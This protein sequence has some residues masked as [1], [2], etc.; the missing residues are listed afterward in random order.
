M[1]R[2]ILFTSISLCIL[3]TFA[4]TSAHA[5]A[6]WSERSSKSYLGREMRVAFINEGS[7]KIGQIILLSRGSSRVKAKYFASGDVAGK[8]KSFAKNKK[9]LFVSSGAFTGSS[10]KP[11]GLTIDN[12]ET[13]NRHIITPNSP[14]VKKLER[15]VTMDGLVIVEAVGGVRATDIKRKY[16][17][18]YDENVKHQIDLFRKDDLN[19]FFDWAKK[20]RA[21]V[22]Q[23]MLLAHENNLMVKKSNA[24]FNARERRFLVLAKDT[25][26]ILYHIIFYFTKR[27]FLNEIAENTYKYLK[28]RKDMQVI[29][30]L[31]LDTGMYNIQHVYEPYDGR[32][33]TDY[34]GHEEVDIDN[35][36]NL[37]A[38]YY[39]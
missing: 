12:G 22:F 34:R 25:N 16:L 1:T 27:Y 5:Y 38:Y 26:G 6:S 33:L 29:A 15:K 35:A 8:Y 11:R 14:K 37:L 20:Y 36:T 7:R 17:N 9:V 23:T 21:T 2:S 39:E 32:E 18:I 24:R 4:S 10:G 31:N 13:V 3:L 30:M 19:R 28:H